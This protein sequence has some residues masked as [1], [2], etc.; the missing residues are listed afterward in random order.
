MARRVWTVAELEQMAPAE[1]DAAFE[2][3]IVADLREVP[4]AFLERV[5]A[6]IEQR[7]AEAEA[8]DQR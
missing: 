5:R 1:Q 6:R 4:P 8:T 7:I 3:S 2:A